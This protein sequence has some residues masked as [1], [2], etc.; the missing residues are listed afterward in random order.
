MQGRG[1]AVVLVATVTLAGCSGAGGGDGKDPAAEGAG[2]LPMLHG[3]VLDPAVRPLAGATVKVLDT[4]ASTLVDDEGFFGFDG[5]PVDQFLVVVATM[6][7]FMPTSKQIT[8][9]ADRSFVLNFTLEPVP[10]ATPYSTVVKKEMMLD[11]QVGI[12]MQEE[13]NQVPC[14]GGVQS[15][16]VDTWDIAV[17][18]GLSGV[19]VEMYWEPTTQLAES[20]GF[21]LE[22]LELGQLN[23]V[24]GQ[25]VGT[26]PQVIRVPQSTA[27]RYY[28]AGG[29][30][31]LTVYAEPN[32][33]ENEVGVGAAVAVQQPVAA[34]GTLFYVAPADPT[35]TLGEAG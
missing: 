3:Y 11:C 18:P 26:S 24:L 16:A 2:A 15:E 5:L 9:T 28:S 6:D 23:L 22:T 34:Y 1:L 12:V 17:E 19:V 31:R 20:L 30:M 29:L 7:G 13:Y 10:V 21:R 14:G 4:N 25:V 27:E 33:D 32:A 35:Y 8:L